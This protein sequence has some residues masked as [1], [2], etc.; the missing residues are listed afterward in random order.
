MDQHGHDGEERAPL[1]TRRA[2]LALA[3]AVPLAAATPGLAIAP[4]RPLD[5]A[6]PRDFL[7]ACL[8]MRAATDGR[9]MMGFV[10]GK[11]YG[12]VGRQITYLFDLLAG[13]FYLYR[14]N[15]DGSW[16][17][18]Y[19][20]IAYFT[21]PA[22]GEPLDD[23]VNPYTNQRVKVPQTR[24]GPSNATLTPDGRIV[25]EGNMTREN[26]FLP[27]VTVNDDVWISERTIVA[28]PAAEGR[29]AFNY[30]ELTVAHASKRDLDDPAQPF[31]RSDVQ[32]TIV[33]SWRPWL[34]MGDRPGHMLASASG[35]TTDQVE[36]MPPRYV[37]LGRRHHGDFFADP[38]GFMTKDW[39]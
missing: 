6:Q 28:A 14:P 37:A 38:A 23:F 32:V 20:E 29:P 18:R 35:T 8:K 39:A 12:V 33:V 21:D 4:R 25:A 16:R 30:N 9:L 2:T 3:G 10:I 7:T 17:R 13:A 19:F 36:R 24:L 15:P 31:V 11:Y 5:L 1:L 22:T 34:E 27:A 26:R